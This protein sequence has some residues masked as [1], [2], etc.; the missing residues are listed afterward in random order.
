MQGFRAKIRVGIQ[1]AVAGCPKPRC[2]HAKSFLSS[3]VWCPVLFSVPFAVA[4]P[5]CNHYTQLDRE[6]LHVTRTR[7]TGLGK[8]ARFEVLKRDGFKCTYCGARPPDVVLVV[9]HVIPVAKG[10]DN[11][12]E[13]LTSAC[14]PCNQ[15]KAARELSSIPMSLAAKAAEAVRREAEILARAEALQAIKDRIEDDAWAVA[16][17]FMAASASDDISRKYF[18]SIVVFIKRLP[19]PTVIEAMETAVLRFP[20]GNDFTFRYFCGICWRII[21]GTVPDGAEE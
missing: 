4:C 21:K 14:K 3:C 13:N 9:D 17:I 19:T 12:T 6:D 16:D 11:S 2:V 10:G 7:R 20:R 5:V 15:G 18:G 8:K 1:T